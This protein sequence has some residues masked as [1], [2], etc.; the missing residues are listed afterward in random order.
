MEKNKTRLHIL[1]AI[2]ICMA[3]G[4]IAA[5]FAVAASNASEP[6]LVNGSS[7]RDTIPE[8]AESVVFTDI[9]APN[10]ALLTDVS[11]K[12]NNSVVAWL[13]DTTYKVS[14]Q[15]TGVKAIGNE[16]CS[17]MF[18]TEKPLENVDTAFLDMTYVKKMP[19]KYFSEGMEVDREV[20]ESFENWS[21][22]DVTDMSKFFD[23]VKD[24]DE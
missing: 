7:F 4:G 15:K 19:W 18:A 23:T 3:L 22:S 10:K 5:Y 20:I 8:T 9:K 16:D 24:Q 17:N 1:M 11:E 12:Q 13:D 2:V 21:T 6:V 14:T